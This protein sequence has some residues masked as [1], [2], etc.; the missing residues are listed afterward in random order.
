MALNPGPLEVVAGGDG[1]GVVGAENSLAVCEGLLVER[2][3]LIQP[4]RRPIGVCEAVT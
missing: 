1:A 3:C 2:D 4:A